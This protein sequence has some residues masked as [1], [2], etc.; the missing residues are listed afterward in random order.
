MENIITKL[1]V[2][3]NFNINR[4]QENIYANSEKLDSTLKT[5]FFNR[6]D[7]F[8]NAD[9]KALYTFLLDLNEKSLFLSNLEEDPI[10]ADDFKKIFAR[11]IASEPNFSELRFISTA[12]TSGCLNKLLKI[13][14]NQHFVEYI[15]SYIIRKFKNEII[16]KLE[17]SLTLKK[18]QLSSKIT[19]NIDE[20]S[21]SLLK[22]LLSSNGVLYAPNINI[23]NEISTIVTKYKGYVALSPFIQNQ[24]KQLLD[25]TP[26]KYVQDKTENKVLR[27]LSILLKDTSGNPV[28]NANI[29]IGEVQ[30]IT[31]N[32]GKISLTIPDG[33][34]TLNIQKE[35]N[36]ETID[37]QVKQ[38]TS[39]NVI[40]E[41]NVK[42]SNIISLGYKTD[43]HDIQSH[44]E[45]IDITSLQK[46][47]IPIE[48][49][50]N[51]TQ[52][53][54][55]SHSGK[56]TFIKQIVKQIIISKIK[57]I[58][59][60][61]KGEYLEFTNQSNF[62]IFSLKSSN[63]DQPLKLNI[64]AKPD[65]SQ[66]LP[67]DVSS[68]K[69]QA[70]FIKSLFTE[71]FLEENKNLSEKQQFLL[72]EAVQKELE[73]TNPNYE[74]LVNKIQ[75]NPDPDS[76]SLYTLFKKY[77]FLK[78]IFYTQNS[79]N[80]SLKYL[81]KQN[82][83]INLSGKGLQK[84]PKYSEKKLLLYSLLK[85]LESNLHLV[86]EKQLI[87][88]DDGATQIKDN[89]F[90]NESISLFKNLTSKYGIILSGKNALLNLLDLSKTITIHKQSNKNSV[91]DLIT[92]LSF[93]EINKNNDLLENIPLGTCFIKSSTYKGPILYYK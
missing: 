11:I 28:S 68:T 45:N 83:L 59:I 55:T 62:N 77:Q 22:D 64:F 35:L 32:S 72:T 56:T 74:S 63:Q 65:K 58:I 1:L 33:S 8:D 44:Q 67:N 10:E 61:F 80:T 57:L 52:V 47:S 48:D 40:L 13:T 73:E 89:L 91:Q 36:T 15:P 51:I 82:M 76:N 7:K 16:K 66:T 5:S 41:P 26:N 17:N 42:L 18:N 19:K 71:F 50:L 93:E 38:D 34:Y 86:N 92:N 85:I 9:K 87:V 23:Q 3:A 49:L 25:Y 90:K 78:N 24:L 2:T 39:I 30:D 21:K 31:D 79:S 69:I 27:K 53:I 20:K 14:K 88:I 46:V 75:D 43:L 6:I 84:Q 81:N 12:E 29:K 70:N 37:I 54:G 60:D 4:I